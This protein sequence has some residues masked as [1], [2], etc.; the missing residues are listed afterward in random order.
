M[1]ANSQT[2]IRFVYEEKYMKSQ[3]KSTKR[4]KTSSNNY[5]TISPVNGTINTTKDLLK[6]VQDLENRI[7]NLEFILFKNLTASSDQMNQMNYLAQNYHMISKMTLENQSEV[8]TN[9][10]IFIQKKKNN[11]YETTSPCSDPYEK[12]LVYDI[13]HQE[14]LSYSKSNCP[15]LNNGLRSSSLSSTNSSEIDSFISGNSSRTSISLDDGNSDPPSWGIILNKFFMLIQHSLLGIEN[16]QLENEFKIQ[17]KESK[18]IEKAE[19]VDGTEKQ[20]KLI[21]E[22]LKRQ[23]EL[24]ELLKISLGGIEYAKRVGRTIKD[25]NSE[26]IEKNKTSQ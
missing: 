19:R 23:N 5:V 9:K 10:T 16:K 8:A 11:F 17:C 2:T 18:K 15:K 20:N 6:Y 25:I 24:I 7:Q 3:K 26:E 13:F 14:T 12:L 21:V 22:E 1:S 4:R